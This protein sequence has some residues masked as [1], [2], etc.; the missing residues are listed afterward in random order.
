MALLHKTLLTSMVT[1]SL[2][3]GL[4][5]QHPM[6]M[7]PGEDS[8]SRSKTKLLASGRAMF[9]TPC[10]AT[11]VMYCRNHEPLSAR[12]RPSR[13]EAYFVHDALVPALGQGSKRHPNIT[14]AH[15]S[16]VI[17]RREDVRHRGMVLEPRQL[18]AVLQDALRPCVPRIGAHVMQYHA[19]IFARG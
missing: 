3:P 12:D 18:R 8:P 1:A 6:S 16:A 19:P 11:V 7:I 10:L 17:A 13:Q 2:R 5:A 9:E 4:L 15:M 14:Q